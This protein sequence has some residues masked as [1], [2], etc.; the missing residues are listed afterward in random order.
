MYSPNVLHWISGIQNLNLQNVKLNNNN[1]KDLKHLK[2]TSQKINI[3]I[4]KVIL[5]K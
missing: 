4:T 2:Q 1:K 5:I 3:I